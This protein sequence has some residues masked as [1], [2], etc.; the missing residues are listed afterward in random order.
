MTDG[1]GKRKI[2][3]GSIIQGAID[4]SEY[5]RLLGGI[6][7][8]FLQLIVDDGKRRADIP[9]YIITGDD[10]KREI[11]AGQSMVTKE[12]LKHGFP[13][14]IQSYH[15]KSIEKLN[16]LGKTY[17]SKWEEEKVLCK[18][19]TEFNQVTFSKEVDEGTDEI[20]IIIHSPIQDFIKKNH[21]DIINI[22]KQYIDNHP[23]KEKVHPEGKKEYVVKYNTVESFVCLNESQKSQLRD[24]LKFFEDGAVK[25]PRLIHVVLEWPL[26]SLMPKPPKSLSDCCEPKEYD[27][28][29]KRLKMHTIRD[30]CFSTPETQSTTWLIYPKGE[31]WSKES[32][33]KRF[34]DLSFDIS[35]TLGCN[36]EVLLHCYGLTMSCDH[37]LFYDG[38]DGLFDGDCYFSEEG[39]R[40][41]FY[42]CYY[43]TDAFYESIR[44][45][46]YLLNSAEPENIGEV[47][48]NA[49]LCKDVAAI[50]HIRPFSVAR[51]LR[52]ANFPVWKKANKNYCDPE[53]AALLFPKWKK[54]LKRQQENE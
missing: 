5:R 39:F 54:H 46:K 11:T 23:L 25:Y 31:S 3:G 34:N 7:E 52:A 33:I 17:P 9:E 4:F 29:L 1:K 48:S 6:E 16:E 44:L 14:E 21:A 42:N 13:K 35:S 20:N 12:E 43:I 51:T 24:L 50:V 26:L 22:R 41:G 37:H 32:G 18:K 49:V 8:K 19:L 28:M 53:R 27:Y 40:N 15:S 45:C 38:W 36:W 30:S 47:P 10:E 2:Q